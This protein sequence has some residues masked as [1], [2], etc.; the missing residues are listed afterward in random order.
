[1]IQITS[2]GFNNLQVK[3]DKLTNLNL[4]KQI[5]R[6]IAI[7]GEQRIGLQARQVVYSHPPS[8][9]YRR[10]GRLLGGRSS[11]LTSGTPRVTAKGT[12]VLLE[13]NPQFRGAKVNY[14]RFVNSGTRRMKARP[15]WDTAMEDLKQNANRIIN[16]FINLYFI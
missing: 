9:R 16:N 15:F 10:T 7:Y 8:P 13:A 11:A 6:E 5:V 1:M 12:Q 4:D 3:I 2:T 14:A